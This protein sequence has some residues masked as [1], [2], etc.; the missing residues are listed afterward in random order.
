M[1]P[2][3]SWVCR[4][5]AAC[6]VTLQMVL[7][8]LQ[9]VLHGV[10]MVLHG[11]QMVP[12]KMKVGCAALALWR[13]QQPC[14]LRWPPLMAPISSQAEESA[15][16]KR[17]DCSTCMPCRHS[18]TLRTWQG[19]PAGVR[20]KQHAAASLHPVAQQAAR[21]VHACVQGS[22]RRRPLRLQRAVMQPPWELLQHHPPGKESGPSGPAWPATRLSTA[23]GQRQTARWATGCGLLGGSWQRD[24]SC[25]DS[26]RVSHGCCQRQPACT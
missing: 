25:K 10:Q 14:S 15:V 26:T 4:R 1:Q 24:C 5:A 12:S 20:H 22:P 17:M 3:V 7:H 11:V 6:L 18:R 8:G 2:V 13:V 9:M 21:D 16:R 23:Q 19:H